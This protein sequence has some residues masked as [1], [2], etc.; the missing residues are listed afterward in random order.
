[1]PSGPRPLPPPRVIRVAVRGDVGGQ[2]FVNVFHA[3]T[4]APGPQANED[5]GEFL[6]E[7]KA[8]LISSG[9]YDACH[10]SVHVTQLTG[11]LQTDEDNALVA[12]VSSSI[13]GAQS[14]TVLPASVCYVVSWL[15]GAFW[16][17]GKPRTYVPGLITASVDTNH[18]LADSD[19]ATFAGNWADLRTA[20]NAITTDSIDQTTMGFVSYATGGAWRSSSVFF[21]YTGSTIH[22]RLASQRRRLGS[23]LP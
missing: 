1:M 17:G 19:K 14:G 23:W 6:D 15:S 11:V 12:Q 7:F 10:T 20:V 2:P 18:S 9:V 3:Q 5:I 13:V 4:D 22:D 16:R 8:A 21:G